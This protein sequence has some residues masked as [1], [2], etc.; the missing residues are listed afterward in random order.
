[1]TLQT[2]DLSYFL[3]KS[4]FGDASF[5]NMFVQPTLDT[6]KLKKRQVY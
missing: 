3:G 6:L 1:M 2:L 5:Q 4:L